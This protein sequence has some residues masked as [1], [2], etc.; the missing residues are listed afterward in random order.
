MFAERV[1]EDIDYRT[2][3]TF[4]PNVSS[5]GTS[6]LTLLNLPKEQQLKQWK[7]LAKVRGKVSEMPWEARRSCCYKTAEQGRCGLVFLVSGGK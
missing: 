7:I 1:K 2:T 3:H 4:L 5:S 6:Q